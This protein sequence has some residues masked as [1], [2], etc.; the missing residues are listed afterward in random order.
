MVP[1]GPAQPSE[2]MLWSELLDLEP[3]SDPVPGH[4]DWGWIP[5]LEGQFS[6]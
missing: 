6:L 5:C 2:Y 3:S 4:L 1:R